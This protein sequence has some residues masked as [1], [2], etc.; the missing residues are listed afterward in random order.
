[1][2]CHPQ[3]QCCIPTTPCSHPRDKL[4]KLVGGSRSALGVCHA[5]TWC[6]HRTACSGDAVWVS[7]PP[8]PVAPSRCPKQPCR[9][10][11]H[12]ISTS[13]RTWMSSASTW[14]MSL[15]SSWKVLARSWLPVPAPYFTR[16]IFFLLPHFTP[17]IFSPLTDISGWWKGRL[18]GREG[19]F[20]GNY[21]QKI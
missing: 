1:M 9:A 2:G 21:V 15:T 3:C 7:G 10:A 11:G 20:P 6:P 18:H 5:H 4:G 19:L 16:W 8:Q 12:F 14:E 17:S 13:G